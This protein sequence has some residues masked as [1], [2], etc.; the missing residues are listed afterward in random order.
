[1]ALAVLGGVDTD[2]AAAAEL[3]NVVGEIHDI[4]ARGQHAVVGEFETPRRAEIDR[5]IGGHAG[6]VRNRVTRGIYG[7]AAILPQAS[8]VN[9]IHIDLRAGLVGFLPKIGSAEGARDT[10]I[11]VQINPMILDVSQGRWIEK[12]LRRAPVF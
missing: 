1:Q 12:K 2:A 6:T 4:N 11:V 8:A 10:L 7:S 9:C 3:V 5:V